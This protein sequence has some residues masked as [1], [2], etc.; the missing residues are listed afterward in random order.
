MALRSR[1][2]AGRFFFR[3][4]A[5]SRDGC[6]GPKYLGLRL[7][8]EN[9]PGSVEIASESVIRTQLPPWCAREDCR[10]PLGALVA[11]LDEASTCSIAMHDRNARFGVSVHLAGHIVDEAPSTPAHCPITIR[12]TP[13]RV[14]RNLA[15]ADVEVLAGSEERLVL[16]GSHIKFMP[17]GWLLDTIGHPWMRPITQQYFDTVVSRWP[18]KNVMDEESIGIGD[19]FAL[20]GSNLAVAPDH[21]NPLGA[22]HGGAACMLSAHVACQ[23]QPEHFPVA[24]RAN[25]MAASKPGDR[26]TISCRDA[27]EFV[28]SQRTSRARIA[29]STGAPAVETTIS[30]IPS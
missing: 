28:G 5:R 22:L 16:R 8:D 27:A 3:Y 30:F 24:L 7:N 26:I 4:S 9:R 13:Q 14:G 17:G 20:E 10:A 15:F 21:C 11:L 23:Q 2:S 18:V 25:L 29:T 1:I 19:V 12:T 6:F